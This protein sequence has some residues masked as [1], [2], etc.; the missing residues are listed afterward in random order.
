VV[1]EKTLA[2][3]L[4]TKGIKPVNPKGNQLFNTHWKDGCHTTIS[5]SV[6]PFSCLQSFP[7][8][9]SFTMSQFVSGGQ[10]IEVS[11]SASVFPMSVKELISFRINWFDPLGVQGTRKSLLQ[12]HSSKASILQRS[13]FFMVQLSHPY[14]TI[15]KTIALTRWLFVVKV[16]SR[17]FNMLSRLVLAFLPRSKHL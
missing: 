11:A 16:M 3:S 13:I 5:S 10:S 2:S 7:A 8:S 4:D 14:V 6:V 17:L 12:H 1:L 9:G 15:G